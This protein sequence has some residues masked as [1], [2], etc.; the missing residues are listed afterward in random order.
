MNRTLFEISGAPTKY[1]I[2]SVEHN[3]WWKQSQ[4][5]YSDDLSE[6]GLFSK[7][8]AKEIIDN[9][10]RFHLEDVMIPNSAIKSLSSNGEGAYK[11][12]RRS[13]F[14]FRLCR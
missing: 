10:N 8:K 9:A 1:L 3:G 12:R 5:G 14:S 2:W 6:A 4:Y 11:P 7:E 13:F